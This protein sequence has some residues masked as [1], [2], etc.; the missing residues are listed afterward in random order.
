VRFRDVRDY[1]AA[2]DERLT[3]SV[4]Q[5]IRSERPVAVAVSGGLDSSYVFGT[6]RRLVQADPSLCPAVLGFSYGG[7]PGSPSDETPYVDALERH[8]RTT[9]DRLGECAGFLAEAAD[10]VWHSESPRIDRLARHGRAVRRAI[11]RGGAARLL[12]GQW[13]DQLL[14]DSDYLLDLLRRGRWRTLARH[15][16]RWRIGT[17]E[18]VAQL[19]RDVMVR[20]VPSR[21]VS[22]VRTA[23]SH[24]GAWEW[25]WFSPRFRR[26]LRERYNAPR[27]GWPRGTSHARAIYRQARL[28]Y[29]VQCMEWN[30]RVGAMDGLDVAFP[31]LDP[32]LIQFLISIPGDMQSCGGSQ[33]G[34]MREAMRG[35]VPES[36]ARRSSKGEFTH[37]GRRS[38][39]TEFVSIRELLGPGALLVELGYVDGPALW[40]RLERWRET[41]GSADN[42][43]MATRLTNLCGLELFLRQFVA[44]EHVVA[45]ADARP[46][47]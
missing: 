22:T 19:V 1:A 8:C 14:A 24:D 2:L 28:G 41:I 29:H 44:R 27:P 46:A 32:D 10:E 18:L 25:P 26:V 45:V 15:A 11:K 40:G 43:V 3:A 5:R 38:L 17:R 16:A 20:S 12:T 33:R 39:E 21:I 42:S 9:I 34:L 4:D 6:A 23:R 35:T 31:Y 13:G 30:V 7:P 47:C 37:L 36:I